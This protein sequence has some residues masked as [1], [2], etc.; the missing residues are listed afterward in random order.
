MRKRI[1]VHW[2]TAWCCE[3]CEHMGM[4]FWDRIENW[5]LLSCDPEFKYGGVN[6]C[7]EEP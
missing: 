1:E 4:L 3:P 2:R 5:N 7:A 6:P